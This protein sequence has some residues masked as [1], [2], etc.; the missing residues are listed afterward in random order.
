MAEIYSIDSRREA[1]K[2]TYEMMN[3]AKF[4]EQ[5][6][7]L[8]SIRSISEDEVRLRLV[9]NQIA[10]QLPQFGLYLS[11]DPNGNYTVGQLP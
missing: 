1:C 3:D 11:A 8:E 7:K 10:N 5:T 4:R 2:R 9:V 6:N